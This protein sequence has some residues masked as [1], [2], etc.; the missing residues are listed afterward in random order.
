MAKRWTIG[1][2][3]LMGFIA[4][5][6]LA[7]AGGGFAV[8]NFN[9]FKGELE[10]LRGMNSNLVA[11]TDKLREEVTPL[12]QLNSVIKTNVDQ[13]VGSSLV[14]IASLNSAESG[15]IQAKLGQ[16][17]EATQKALT[18]SQK[19]GKKAIAKAMQ[20][21]LRGIDAYGNAV[22]QVAGEINKLTQA[23][24]STYASCAKITQ[25]SK[26]MVK[27]QQ[28]FFNVEKQTGDT[29]AI[30]KRIDIIERTQEL[31]KA[32]YQI[33]TA[34]DKYLRTRS[35]E[36]YEELEILGL[37][38]VG[39]T[40]MLS[41][42]KGMFSKIGAK[43]L[44]QAR[45]AFS[46]SQATMESLSEIMTGLDESLKVMQA[47]QKTIESA[48]AQVALQVQKL[49]AD[50][51]KQVADFSAQA[52]RAMERSQTALSEASLVTMASVA[53]T[54]FVGL[55]LAMLLTR[56]LVKSVGTMAGRLSETASEVNDASQKLNDSSYNLAEGAS[57]QAASL[58]E[59][60]ASLEELN[61]M[62]KNNAEN[63]D[64][65]RVLM[66]KTEEEG[67]Q[68]SQAMGEL[69][70]SMREISEAS[71]EIGRIIKTIDEIAFQ[72]N[73]LALN[74]AVEAARAGEAG[75]GFAVVADEVRS[76]ALRAAE[77]ASETQGLI[78]NTRTKIETGTGALESTETKFNSLIESTVKVSTL[79]ADIASASQE[80]TM[81][82]D[83]ISTAM[84]RIDKITQDTAFLA[85]DSAG[86]A[87]L[88]L[89]Q[90]DQLHNMLE[91]L[92]ELAGQK[93]NGKNR[94]RSSEMIAKEEAAG[95][96][97]ASSQA[98]LEGPQKTAEASGQDSDFENF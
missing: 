24:E 14:M 72:T 39:M 70:Q 86:S 59:T 11:T 13:A 97:Q 43:D 19:T 47:K 21:A 63:A 7:G 98:M 9:N 35:E 5:I 84:G 76:L 4:V 26:K 29:K 34:V 64:Q 36:A 75:A 65:A 41:T 31:E 66:A 62:T 96:K 54:L 82:I 80:Q 51:D 32:A 3:T 12:S 95:Q 71:S 94:S 83:Q 92:L 78:K 79:I 74:A 45:E 40:Q 17:K 61:S 58:E 88:L 30:T 89:G 28:I 16:A 81:G 6:I 67:H 68:A 53:A 57:D 38:S 93:Q 8:Y 20:T 85:Q 15:S 77:A 49:A 87:K 50:S 48:I 27:E 18:M 10:K 60:S 1:R 42:R 2:R 37:R 91:E 33:Q 44:E 90:A 25:L 69:G 52:D 56:G 46:N 73:L 23:Q 55:L 22:K